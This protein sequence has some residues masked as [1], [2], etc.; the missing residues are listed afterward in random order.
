LKGLSHDVRYGCRAFLKNPGFTVIAIATLAIGIGGNTAI[1][2]FVNAA[3]L[4]PLPY[5]DP[6]R[7]VQVLEKPPDGGRNGISTSTLNYLDWKNDNTVFEYLAARTGGA[8][9]LTGLNEPLQ[10][11]GSRV[12]AQYFDIFGVKVAAGRTFMDGEDEPGKDHVAILSHGLWQNRGQASVGTSPKPV[13]GST[14]G[15]EPGEESSDHGGGGFR[16]PWF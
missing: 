3:L 4:K 1:F 5:A 12:S 9:T 14:I 10:L 2:S 13:C 7:I 15:G 11:R 6:D 8:V 16:V